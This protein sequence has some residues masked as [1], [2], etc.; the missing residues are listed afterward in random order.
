MIFTPLRVIIY[1]VSKL[2]FLTD[3][4]R[5]KENVRLLPVILTP[6]A[7]WKEAMNMG[8]IILPSGQSISADEF[9]GQLDISHLFKDLRSNDLTDSYLIAIICV[10][11]RCGKHASQAE[12]R[13][14]EISRGNNPL[15]KQAAD[16]ALRKIRTTTAA[17][18]TAKFDD[19]YDTAAYYGATVGS[20]VGCPN[21]AGH[22]NYHRKIDVNKVTFTEI[23]TEDLDDGLQTYQECFFCTKLCLATAASRVMSAK[24]SGNNFH[25]L[26]CLRNNYNL[27][28]I[29]ARDTMILSLRGLFGYY[30]YAYHIAPKTPAMYI[31]DIRDMIENHITVGLQN[32]IFTYDYETYSWFIDFNRVGDGKNK[33]EL[34]SVLKTLVSMCACFNIYDNVRGIN[35]FKFYKKLEDGVTT[36]HNTRERKWNMKVFVP[37]LWKCGIPGSSVKPIPVEILHGFQPGHLQDVNLNNNKNIRRY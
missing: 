9:P 14:E 4:L 2:N 27:Y 12:A 34:E 17:V 28:N 21:F 6:A 23:N 3:L 36:F 35:G 31:V 16:Q 32:P 22:H 33:I 11:G 8:Q 13:L 5:S 7:P 19:D 24:L 18:H 30:Y 1:L 29:V 37:T 15:L 10:L 20:G 26:F 25:C